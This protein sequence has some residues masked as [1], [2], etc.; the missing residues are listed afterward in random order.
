M[1]VLKRMLSLHREIS[2]LMDEAASPKGCPAL[3]DNFSLRMLKLGGFKQTR[4]TANSLR[5]LNHGVLR[6]VLSTSSANRSSCSI[7]SHG[8]S[9][10]AST[11]ILRSSVNS[12]KSPKKSRSRK[13]SEPAVF[14]LSLIRSKCAGISV[15]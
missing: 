6:L 13:T 5:V 1:G 7:G 4:G 12:R 2:E 14:I 8:T 10:S 3:S 9:F 11:S 15:Q